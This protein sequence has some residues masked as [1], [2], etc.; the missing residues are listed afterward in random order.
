MTRQKDDRHPDAPLLEQPLILFLDEIDIHLH[1][2][3]QRKVLPVVQKLFPNAQIFVSTHSPFVVGSVQDAWVYKLDD[4]KTQKT[5][6]GIPSGA[7]TSYEVLLEEIFDVS[8][9]YDVETQR[10]LAEMKL[11]RNALLA[12]SNAPDV[13][14]KS[15][16]QQ[17]AVRSE[18]LDGVVA[19][20]LR[21]LAK[22][23]R[24]VT[25]EPVAL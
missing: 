8:E 20:E 23:G 2:K 14:F 25:L 11:A 17:I 1:P 21:Q 10:L 9:H 5:I 3:W 7:G 6:V 16:A 12:D 15:L 18:E 13:A 24:I 22:H 19:T 4:A